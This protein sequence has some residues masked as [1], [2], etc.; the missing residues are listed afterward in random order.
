MSF[1]ISWAYVAGDT[2]M[3][4]YFKKHTPLKNINHLLETVLDNSI[5]T[6]K[7]MMRKIYP[8]FSQYPTFVLFQELFFRK[9]INID[10]ATHFIIPA[11]IPKENLEYI[12][13]NFPHIKLVVSVWNHEWWQD[14]E[15]LGYISDNVDNGYQMGY[16][17]YTRQRIATSGK[18]LV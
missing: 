13:T 4:V 3:A 18:E 14:K 12:K 11:N 7:Q 1:Y 15:Y 9:H 16:Q 17:L 2:N 6:A 5:T 10:Q 8:K